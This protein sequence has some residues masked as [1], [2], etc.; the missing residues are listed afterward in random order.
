MTPFNDVCKRIE[1]FIFDHNSMLKRFVVI[2]LS[3]LLTHLSCIFLC[4]LFVYFT[5][6]SHHLTFTE[7]SK[8]LRT[9]FRVALLTGMVF[10]YASY[11]IVLLFGEIQGL[12][13]IFF[14][15]KWLYYLSLYLIISRYSL[16]YISLYSGAFN[17]I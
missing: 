9:N 8:I 7:F 15:K 16:F 11:G 1:S 12:L 14:G 10:T 2:S 13:Y 3:T 6:H 17:H 5:E 4:S